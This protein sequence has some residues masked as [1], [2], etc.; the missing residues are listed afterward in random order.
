MNGRIPF[1]K[2]VIE[3]MERAVG[4]TARPLLSSL[5]TATLPNS[6]RPTQLVKDLLCELWSKEEPAEDFQRALS[7]DDTLVPVRS[8]RCTCSSTQCEEELETAEGRKMIYQSTRCQK[9]DL[10][11]NWR[12]KVSRALVFSNSQAPMTFRL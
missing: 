12:L 7:C 5:D 4:K 11:N 1:Q 6:P 8:W 3:G 9:L 10:G 2:L